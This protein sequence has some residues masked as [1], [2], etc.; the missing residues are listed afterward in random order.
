VVEGHVQ[1]DV[2]GADR[3]NSRDV[4]RC[5]YETR[6]TLLDHDAAL[7]PL[8]DLRVA[9]HD[10]RPPRWLALFTPSTGPFRAI[11]SDPAAAQ[12]L[13]T[14]LRATAATQ[15]GQYQLGLFEADDG[16]DDSTIPADRNIARTFKIASSDELTLLAVRKLGKD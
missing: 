7:P 3:S 2:D 6:V 16:R 1:L 15:A 10:G 9:A 11:F 13:A 4:W 5:S 8:W 14:W 12:A